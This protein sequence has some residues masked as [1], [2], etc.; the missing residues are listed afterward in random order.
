MTDCGIYLNTLHVAY[1]FQTLL[2]CIAALFICSSPIVSHNIS[3]GGICLVKVSFFFQGMFFC[4]LCTNLHFTDNSPT[5]TQDLCCFLML[6]CCY[7]YSNK[8]QR[9][10]TM[11]LIMII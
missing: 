7:F 1:M 11:V 5:I 8:R 3:R 10:K 4:K 2:F 6:F 9:E